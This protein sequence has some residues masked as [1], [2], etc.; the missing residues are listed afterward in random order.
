MERAT[1]KD[2]RHNQ[3]DK[4]F[5]K[6]SKLLPDTLMQQMITKFNLQNK[7]KMK[8]EDNQLKKKSQELK[9]IGK[10]NST[11]QKQL[12]VAEEKL[13]ELMNKISE[14]SYTGTLHLA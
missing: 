5:Y 11:E 12:A 6:A 3:R 7:L 8:H 4:H 10:T 13:K 14:I 1:W 2:Q 9:R